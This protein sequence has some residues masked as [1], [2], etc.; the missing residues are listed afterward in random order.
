MCVCV[1]VCVYV[2]VCVCVMLVFVTCLVFRTFSSTNIDL[3]RTSRPHGDQ[4]L[5]LMRQ[6]VISEVLV[7][8]REK[9]LVRLSSQ[10]NVLFPLSLHSRHSWS[11]EDD[12][13]T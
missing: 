5:V 4:S 12:C 9:S 3:V 10:M 11:S 13:L 6:D 2:C 8:V 7:K 1:C